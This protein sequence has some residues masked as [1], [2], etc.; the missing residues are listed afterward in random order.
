MSVIIRRASH[1]PFFLTEVGEPLATPR[2]PLTWHHPTSFW[3]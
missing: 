2:T 3:F 1:L